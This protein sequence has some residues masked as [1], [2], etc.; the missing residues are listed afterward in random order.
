MEL[1]YATSPGDVGC[2]A[3][4]ESGAWVYCMAVYYN[5]GMFPGQGWYMGTWGGAAESQSYSWFPVYGFGGATADGSS[6]VAFDKPL[7][8]P[9][10]PFSINFA[11]LQPS[12]DVHGQFTI[13]ANPISQYLN[14]HFAA[15]VAAALNTEFRNN[16]LPHL[17]P[18]AGQWSVNPGPTWPDP[19]VPYDP[20][21]SD[22]SGTYFGRM[23]GG[24]T[25]I[26]YSKLKDVMSAAG[27]GSDP[28]AATYLDWYQKAEIA[29]KQRYDMLD[30]AETK[31]NW[32]KF[33]V[34]ASLAFGG[35]AALAA[36]S[37]AAASSA[38]IGASEVLKAA[39]FAYKAYNGAQ[40]LSASIPDDIGLTRPV[41]SGNS[42]AAMQSYVDSY[43]LNGL[44]KSSYQSA[45]EGVNAA[46]DGDFLTADAKHAEALDTYNQAVE[47]SNRSGLAIPAS[48]STGIQKGM[49]LITQIETAPP[50]AP[51]VEQEAPAAITESSAPSGGLLDAIVS[52]T[53]SAL[54][55]LH[56][57]D[58]DALATLDETAQTP[59]VEAGMSPWIAAILIGSMAISSVGKKKSTRKKRR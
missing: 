3:D 33:A 14:D 22:P 21:V 10:Y 52:A 24:V 45:L 39:Q 31:M 41:P 58:Q 23:I 19:G 42:I 1:K 4:W 56:P 17:N 32:M 2:S 50:P 15:A 5:N 8:D 54:D 29:A 9:G 49:N 48:A 38:G 53:G 35:A 59:V 36:I 18:A 27:A 25:Y 34:A 6:Y 7:P 40:T 16:I 55:S 11:T 20:V 43:T 46:K 37:T 51:V 28:I 57:S 47:T 44:L 26:S 13:G 30:K 12:W